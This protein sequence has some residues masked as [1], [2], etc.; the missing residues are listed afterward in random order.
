MYQ[1]PREYYY[2]IHHIR[3][4]FKENVESVLFFIANKLN[5]LERKPSQEFKELF[6]EELKLFPGNFSKSLKTINNWRTE[7]SALFGFVIEENGY[8]YP[9]NR[10]IELSEKQD[11][12]EFFKIF[13]Y[14]FQYPGAHLKPV[15]VV[16][17]VN[18]GIKFKPAQYILKLFKC[19]DEVPSGERYLSKAEVCH[20]VFNDLRCTR[21]CEAPE[22]VW[23]RIL[24]N[25]EQDVKYDWTGDVIRYAGDILDYMEIANLLKTYNGYN[26]WINRNEEVA[27]GNFVTGDDDFKG[28]DS[29]IAKK[30][31]TINEAKE[32]SPNWFSYVNRDMSESNFSTDVFALVTEDEEQ[33]SE[34]RDHALS[35]FG[36]KLEKGNIT[37]KEIGDLGESI[38]HEHE[39]N[40]IKEAGRPDLVH[41]IKLIPTHFSVGYD[42]QSIETN[43]Q[44]RLIEVKSTIS[45]KPLM[46]KSFHLTTNEWRSADSYKDRYYVYRLMLS[47]GEMKLFVLQDPV[48]KYKSDVLYMVPKN[49]GVD[50]NF[51]DE[52]AGE[53]EEL[54]LNE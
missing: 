42:L 12:I 25:R 38:A 34:M 48:G 16:S 54:L 6:I 3:P 8:T 20:L 35:L 10:A 33:Y 49:D 52:T 44:K 40:R 43:E 36:T 30:Q 39:C 11:L 53:Y 37:T 45:S 14:N 51:D 26:F 46:F 18:S 32:Q 21:D 50:I 24:R 4:R 15:E 28:Y 1:T 31:I 17:M 9:S 19:V 13:L 41:L 23:Q 47:K 5:D 2:R 22:N 27:I 29:Y 7:I